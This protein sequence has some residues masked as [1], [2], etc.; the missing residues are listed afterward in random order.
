MVANGDW[1]TPRLDAI[2]YFEKPPLQYWA[3]AVAFEGFGA[4]EWTTRLWG[5]LTGAA[6]IALTFWL[7]R[8]VWVSVPASSRPRCKPARCY[9]P[10]SDI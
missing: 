5:A 10:A 8:R 7:G 2:K 1:V 3:T 6:G 4:H 9:M